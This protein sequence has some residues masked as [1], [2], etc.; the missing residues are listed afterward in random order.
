MD[1]N[2]TLPVSTQE[3]LTEL[4]L[5]NT[6]ENS[7]VVGGLIQDSAD[8][9]KD[10]VNKNLSASELAEDHIYIRA[11]KALTTALFYDRSLSQGMPLGVQLMITHLK[12]EY[13]S[14]PDK[15]D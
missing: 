5:D 13:E 2:D 9:V 15:Q 3:V 11:V 10:S 12:G 7:A 4:N 6:P 8:I 1:Q 14:W